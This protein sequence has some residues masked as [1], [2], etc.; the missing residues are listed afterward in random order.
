MSQCKIR[1]LTSFP[2]TLAEMTILTKS[3]WPLYLLPRV[4]VSL[5]QVQI[6]LSQQPAKIVAPPGPPTATEVTGAVGPLYTV[7]ESLFLEHC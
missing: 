2:P 7:F 6:S 4:L 3:E 5:S 1:A